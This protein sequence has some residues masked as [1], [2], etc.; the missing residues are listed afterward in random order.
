MILYL[1]EGDDQSQSMSIIPSFFAVWHLLEE[2]RA[3]FN[4]ALAAL[5][6]VARAGKAWLLYLSYLDS[7]RNGPYHHTCLHI[8]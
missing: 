4:V 7:A 3:V 2:S 8:C 5:D 6:Q 1:C